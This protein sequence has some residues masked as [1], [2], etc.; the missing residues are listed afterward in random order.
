[1][2]RFS[3]TTNNYPKNEYYFNKQNFASYWQYF[4][5]EELKLTKNNFKLQSWFILLL[6]A[7]IFYIQENPVYVTN[8]STSINT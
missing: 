3:N 7:K 2:D 1:M 5:L 6:S 8:I 4:N